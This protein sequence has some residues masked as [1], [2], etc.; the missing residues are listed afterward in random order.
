MIIPA[1][2]TEVEQI[3]LA[4]EMQGCRSVCVTSC[5]PGDGVT[6]IVTALAERY[7]FSGYKTLLV[8]LN[9]FHPAFEG[10]EVMPIEQSDE[11][12]GTLIS[13][14]H[15]HQLFTGLTI[16]NTQAAILPFK[17]PTHLSSAVNH[18]LKEYDRVIFDTT[19]ILHIN[20]GSI[21]AQVV[22]S[23]CDQT[24]MV[25]MGGST[26]TSQLEKAMNLLDNK[27]ISLLGSI[28]NLKQQASLGQELV[29][30]L[31]RFKFIPQS[32]RKRLGDRILAND[33]LAQT[34]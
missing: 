1:T 16:P 30:E 13:H 19:P 28:L 6:S 11:H 32:W 4:A 23:A 31:N 20:R 7:L 33:F 18:W 27:S 2:H 15:T 29:R 17:D 34:A 5:Q 21:P 9:T 14:S 12:V 26:S 22:A 3:Y 8:D 10:V 24:I 25:I